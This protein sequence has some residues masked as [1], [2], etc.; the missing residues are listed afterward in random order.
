[1]DEDEVRPVIVTL[2]RT[3]GREM[4]TGYAH[5]KSSLDFC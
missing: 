5:A 1:M 3:G 4:N 2:L